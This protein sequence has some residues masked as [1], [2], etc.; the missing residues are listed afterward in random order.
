MIEL[1]EAVKGLI[2]IRVLL[3]TLRVPANSKTMR[4]LWWSWVLLETMIVLLELRKVLVKDGRASACKGHETTSPTSKGLTSDE[5]H[6]V[7]DLH[8]PSKNFMPHIEIMK[9]CQNHWSLLWSSLYGEPPL[10]QHGRLHLQPPR[11]H[12]ESAQLKR[13]ESPL[14]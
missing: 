3:E 10:L 11:L 6:V 14:L 2:E 4:V 7:L 13:G 5:S 9:F 8:C 1:Y 12:G